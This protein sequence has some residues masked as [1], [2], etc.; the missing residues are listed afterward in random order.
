MIEELLRETFVRHEPL[1]PAPEPV[2]ARIEVVAR[3]R[4]RFADARRGAAAAL[5]FVVLVGVGFALAPDGAHRDN[6]LAT[7]GVLGD[8]RGTGPL[9]VLLVGVDSPRGGSEPARP[10]TI[11][12]AHLPA[13]S[14]RAYLISIPRDIKLTDRYLKGGPPALAKA[15]TELTG[16]PV[17]GMVEVE[18]AGLVKI[19]DAV[20]GVDLCVDAR[21]VSEHMGY[22][23]QGRYLHPRD[24]GKPAI[25]E[26]GCRRFTGA[27]ALDYLRQRK[28][29]ADGD[30]GRQ[31]HNRDYVKALLGKLAGADL[32]RLTAVL[33]T[34]GDAV[35]VDLGRYT[36]AEVVF[37]VRDLTPDKVVSISAAATFDELPTGADGLWAALRAGT[38]DSW[39]AAHPDHTR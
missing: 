23:V 10:D 14:A 17:T 4:R 26:P 5:A 28:S 3:R 37:A 13:G 36:L 6:H 18:F 24:G 8:P 21:V 29:L 1:A 35:T 9:N 15:I 16:V 12:L 22:D 32:R 27:E 20:G 7:D 33:A 34:A 2:R 19:T 25:Y 38:L 31:R 30:L 11:M 39:A